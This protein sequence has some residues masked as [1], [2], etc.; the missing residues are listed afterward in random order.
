MLPAPGG[1]LHRVVQCAA[2]TATQSRL[3]GGRYGPQVTPEGPSSPT[4][5]WVPSGESRSLWAAGL[6]A[7][8]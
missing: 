6:R 8:F 5:C 7:S 2:W 3:G 4:Q 1:L